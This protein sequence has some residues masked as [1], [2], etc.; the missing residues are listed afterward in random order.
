M[1]GTILRR[2]MVAAP[3]QGVIMTVAF[4]LDFLDVATGKITT[5]EVDVREK[6]QEAVPAIVREIGQ[7]MGHR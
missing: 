2:E 5:V 7:Q 4:R 3:M 6:F 1:S